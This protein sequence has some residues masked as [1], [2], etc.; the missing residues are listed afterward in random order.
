MTPVVPE[1]LMWEILKTARSYFGYGVPLPTKSLRS[2]IREGIRVSDENY[3][4]ET[5]IAWA[6]GY[7]FLQELVDSDLRCFRAAQLDFKAIVQRRLQ[8][9]NSPRTGSTKSECPLWLT[10][11][12]PYCMTDV[13]ASTGPIQAHWQ[14]TRR[15]T[16]R[17][18]PQG[19]LGRESTAWRHGLTKTG[20]VVAAVVA[21]LYTRMP[22]FDLVAKK[23]SLPQPA[24]SRKAKPRKCLRIFHMMAEFKHLS[25]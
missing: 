6:E 8:L 25:D 1:W 20:F 12:R 11:R 24:G 14:R 4:V 9:L 23:S 10:Q 16:T 21:R 15:G 22:G 7:E 13:S 17:G 18:I 3:G 5:A 19:S 2:L